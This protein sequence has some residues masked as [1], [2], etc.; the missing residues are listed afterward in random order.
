MAYTRA[1][2][3]TLL[4]RRFGSFLTKVG[5]DGTTANGT[6]TDLEDPILSGLHACGIYPADPTNLTDS[7]LT[8]V[9]NTNVNKFL[10]LAELR[11]LENIAGNN[12]LVDVKAGPLAES[13]GQLATTLE[14]RIARLQEKI[15]AKYN[16]NLR[17]VVLR[18]PSEYDE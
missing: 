17:T 9:G 18:V 6:N 4:L 15:N 8:D 14:K 1:Q 10:D 16:L 2:V 7:D 12:T 11:G 5:M 13:L 3:E